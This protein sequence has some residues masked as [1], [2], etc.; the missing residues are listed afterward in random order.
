MASAGAQE[1]GE[2]RELAFGQWARAAH[3]CFD[4]SSFD[5]LVLPTRRL[6][7]PRRDDNRPRSHPRLVWIEISAVAD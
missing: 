4:H 2:G 7:Y 1:I 6:V 5:G 3:Y